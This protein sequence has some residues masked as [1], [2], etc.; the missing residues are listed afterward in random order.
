MEPPGVPQNCVPVCVCGGVSQ[1]CCPHGS[2]GPLRFSDR[3][4]GAAGALC[5]AE[6][7]CICVGGDMGPL[8]HSTPPVLAQE[9][10]SLTASP[11]SCSGRSVPHATC[12]EQTWC[13]QVLGKPG[14]T[15]ALPHV[16]PRPAPRHRAP[17]HAWPGK[18]LQEAALVPR[19]GRSLHTRGEASLVPCPYH[20]TGPGLSLCPRLL[21][22]PQ[23][24]A[25]NHWGH[26]DRAP[27]P[28]RPR[29]SAG[30]PGAEPC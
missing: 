21:R 26:P 18:C 28:G 12:R 13:P 23:A 15:Q 30:A 22:A 29:R 17:A 5:P 8:S 7:V 19:Q 11:A 27:G 14:P 9:A 25:G 10:R 2:P 1:V 16:T 24:P 3:A 4:S 20:P 6:L